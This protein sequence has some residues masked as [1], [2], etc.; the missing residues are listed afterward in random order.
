MKTRL[1]IVAIMLIGFSACAPKYTCP[2]YSINK[3]KEIK[4][5]KMAEV[6]M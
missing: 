3:G 6:P 1:T 4:T 5:E 2:A